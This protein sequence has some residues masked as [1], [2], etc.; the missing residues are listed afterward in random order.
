MAQKR[1]PS[2]KQKRIIL[3]VDILAKSLDTENLGSKNWG[4]VGRLVNQFGVP[5]IKDCVEKFAK[6]KT[7]E[8]RR[9]MWKRNRMLP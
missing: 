1:E 3:V 7:V 2:E 9:T 4:Q 6:A 5:L 8:E